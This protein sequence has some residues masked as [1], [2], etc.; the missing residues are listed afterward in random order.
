MAKVA[1]IT[2]ASS[3]IGAAAARALAGDGFG[4]VLGARRLERLEELAAEVGGEAVALDVAD[5][6]SVEEFAARLPRCDVLVNNAGGALGLEPLGEAD[7][8]QVAHDVR[9]ERAGDDADD[10]GAAAEADRLRRRSRRRDHEHRRLRGLPWRRR[11]H[12]RQARPA[13]DAAGAAPGAARRAGAGD[14]GR[15]GHGRDRVLA[16]P[17]RRRRGGRP[18]RLRGD[19][20]AERRGRRRVHPLGASPNRPTSTS[21][22]SSSAPATRRP[23]SRST[24]TPTS[25]R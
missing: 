19:D 16:G 8:E 14:R 11:L 15:A 23:R 4:V 10:A 2:G 1:V 7:E 5:P 24:G 22:R 18:P 13:L 12:R 21:T 9:G 6:D 20:P 25:S 3:G 17:L